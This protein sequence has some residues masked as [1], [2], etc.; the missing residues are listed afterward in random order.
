MSSKL[1]RFQSN[2]I[3]FLLLLFYGCIGEPEFRPEM[4]TGDVTG[5]K[6]VYRAD[7]DTQITFES[8]RPLKKPG[9]I[10]T[11]PP[12][13]LVNE[14]DEGIHFYLNSDPKHPEPIGFLKI[15][16]NTDFVMKGNIVYAN[17]YSDLLSLN[18]SNKSNIVEL[19]RISQPS[20]V[21]NY[22]PMSEGRFFE[23][24]DPS[25]GILIGWE[26]TT[27]TNPTCYR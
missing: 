18:V 27:I 8:A 17:N 22:P 21:Q 19:S 7:I 16:G 26:L 5:Y 1:H 11:Y 3:L 9:K 23:C 4:P 6:P 10:F 15:D 20:W 24:V 25:K 13:L 2:K 12:Y 14:Q